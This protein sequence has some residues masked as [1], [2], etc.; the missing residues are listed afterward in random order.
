VRDLEIADTHA[1]YKKL[2]SFIKNLFVYVNP[3]GG[4]PNPNSPKKKIRDLVP[5]AG[6]YRFQKNGQ[7][8]T[9]KEHFR[10]AHNYTLSHPRTFGIRV[11]SK[12][13]DIVFPS[14]VC[15]IVE[16]Q[17][18]K[19]K[20]SSEL[21]SKVVRFAT[22]KPQERLD[23]ITQGHGS[24]VPS[25]VL[26]YPTSPFMQDAG[27]QVAKSPIK[28]NGR[29]LPT[30]T[31]FF[32]DKQQLKIQDG[33]WNMTRNQFRTPMPLIAWAVVDYAHK[34]AKV[35]DFTGMLKTCFANLGMKYLEPYMLPANGQGNISNDLRNIANETMHHASGEAAKIP[36]AERPPRP[37]NVALII[38]ILPFPATQTRRDVK[39]FGDVEA[40]ILTQCIREDKIRTG[41]SLNQYCNNV[42]LKI[43]ARLGGENSIAGS[44][45]LSELQK[46]RF[47]VV[48]ADVGH[49]GAGVSTHPSVAS[50]VW[51]YDMHAMKYAAFS[52]VQEPRQENIEEL[53]PMMKRALEAFG[54]MTK[55]PPK[56]IV[57]FRDGLSEGEF[58]KVGAMEIA[59]IQS[60][61]DSIWKEKNLDPKTKPM[62]T[63]IVVGK[64]HH[65]R[66]FPTSPQ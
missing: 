55:G 15:T 53:E 23:T 57:F 35:N 44:K 34:P 54:A 46:A 14:E 13:R 64:R 11:G 17:I 47:M 41:N 65:V 6:E 24:G 62:I 9:V 38:V 25:P 3:T 39:H 19:K 5:F 12:E 43:N 31:L 1:N 18:Y 28:I 60:A 10:A 16:G 51:S 42:A 2:K 37:A 58:E 59:A 56:R 4:P 30:P 8:T 49:P 32:A 27:M 36:P 21:T 26:A 45:A 29:I 20:V 40:G 33:A 50:L 63:Y 66:F 22:R 7:D 48:G 61:I 52:S